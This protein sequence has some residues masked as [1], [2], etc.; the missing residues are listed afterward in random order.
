M[1]SCQ[2]P[3]SVYI[4]TVS[5]NGGLTKFPGSSCPNISKF[6]VVPV[7]VYACVAYADI[8]HCLI[9]HV[10]NEQLNMLPETTHLDALNKNNTTISAIELKR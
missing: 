1:R 8:L 6:W 2:L 7:C 4:L 9:V 10:I 5:L 3:E